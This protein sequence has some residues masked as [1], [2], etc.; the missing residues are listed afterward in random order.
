MSTTTEHD[1]ATT[2]A[3]VN[4]AE[5]ET[6]HAV[7]AHD[8]ATEAVAADPIAADEHELEGLKILALDSAELATRSAQLAANAGAHLKKVTH[9]LDL[10]LAKQKKQTLIM[11]GIAGLLMLMAAAV[12]GAMTVSLKS[13]INLLD[14][15]VSAVGK[16][17]GELDASLEL[18][19]SV[20]EALQE[21]V[22]KQAGIA[23][24]QT[25]IDARIDESIKNSQGVPELTAKQVDA[26]SQVLAKQ[27]QAL[28][29]RLQA[30]ASALKSISSLMQGMQGSLTDNGGLRREMEALAKIQRELQSAEA[31]ANAQAQ[32][33][34]LQ[35]ANAAAAAAAAAAAN[36]ASTAAATAASNA[37]A[38]AAANAAAANAV[39][40][41]ERMVQYP[42]VQSPDAAP[43][44]AG[45]VF[46]SKPS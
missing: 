25:K 18:V 21:M 24:M 44:G 34:S 43:S 27:V 12:F 33:A 20:N 16:R 23:D 28:D 30:Q 11:F 2:G 42:R 13:R 8:P 1:A 3:A 10:S 36:A 6:A 22:G 41:R 35:S 31:K 19:G 29:S 15:M 14:T 7:Q 17:V 37:A 40:Q 26:K 9:N 46:G 5:H 4:T 32:A 38:T 39:K 45:G